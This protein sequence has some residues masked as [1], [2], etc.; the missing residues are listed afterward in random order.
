[1]RV[2]VGSTAAKYWFDDFR[3]P[4][5]RDYIVEAEWERVDDSWVSPKIVEWYRKLRYDSDQI[6]LPDDLYTL[7]ISHAFWDIPTWQKHMTDILFFQDKR[8]TFIRGL[9][10]VAY[11]EWKDRYGKKKANLNVSADEFFNAN[12]ERIYDHDSIHAAVAYGK[13]PLFKSILKDG[14]D[15]AIDMDKFYALSYQDK[16]NLVR[17]EIYATALE[18]YI[19]PNGGSPGL[20]YNNSMRALL[21]SYSKGEFALWVVLNYSQ[22]Y[23]ADINYIERFKTN[24]ERLIRL[25]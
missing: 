11:P 25:W 23:K 12:V 10:D 2:L 9:Y 7:K 22:L 8:C 3:E 15:V 16:L 17:E 4:K 19:I 24:R 13:E 21:T 6:A 18:R 5:D 1:M 14:H 20:A